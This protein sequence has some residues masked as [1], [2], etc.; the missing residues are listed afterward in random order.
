MSPSKREKAAGSPVKKTT[1]TKQTGKSSASAVK[2]VAKKATS[3]KAVPAKPAPAKPAATK[4][5]ATKPAKKATPAKKA[6][7]AFEIGDEGTEV[8]TLRREST[9]QV[10]CVAFVAAGPGDPDLIAH[11]G[12][13][14]LIEA[15]MILSDK[16]AA[17]IAA[18][19]VGLAQPP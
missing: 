10:P 15:E 19:S 17:P 8:S 1:A 16:A 5:A 2:K 14:F 11:R 12:A 9:P 18:A 4:P 6:S 7:A 13:N 3:T